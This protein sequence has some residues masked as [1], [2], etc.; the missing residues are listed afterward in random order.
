[1]TRRLNQTLE[2]LN[3]SNIS[4]NLWLLELNVKTI[5]WNFLWEVLHYLNTKYTTF[6][7]RIKRS[8]E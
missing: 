5:S 3:K 6:L 7:L 8:V 4:Q 2:T 1:M